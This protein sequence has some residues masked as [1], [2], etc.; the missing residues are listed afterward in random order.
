MP[1][2]RAFAG[3]FPLAR[4]VNVA[5]AVLAWGLAIGALPGCNLNAFTVNST[6]P[7][8][9]AGSVALDRESDIQHARAAGPASLLTVE[10]FLV[11]S[12]D[13][14]NLLEILAP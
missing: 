10:T 1:A 8:L 9:K 5:G 7:V 4:R 6:A 11:S 12:P 3:E 2:T 13:N 14:K